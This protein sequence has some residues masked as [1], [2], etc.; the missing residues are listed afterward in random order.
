MSEELV[1]LNKYIA[2]MTGYSR[3][4]ADQLIEE[5]RVSINGRK[6]REQGVKLNV[7]EDAVFIDNEPVFERNV[8]VFKFYK[9][10]KI[11]TAYGDGRGKE[12]LDKYPPFGGRKIPYSGRLDYESEGLILFSTD[13]ELIQRMQKPEYKLEKEYSVIVDRPLNHRELEEFSSGL[14]T[15]KGNYKPCYIRPEGPGKRHYIVIL[16]EGKKRQ[17]RNM[18][19]YFGS[20]V[21][22]L[23]RVR[24]GPIYLGDLNPG[25]Y[26]SLDKREIKEL[27]KSVGLNY[28]NKIINKP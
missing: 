18:F 12:T 1:R 15:P 11:L 7:L 2:S 19:A 16:K 25:E 26:A 28:H 21:K 13:G 20:T 3:R 27:Y 10:R 14:D 6:I 9:P 22:K 5:G 4:E 17:I 24:I 8:E 23:T